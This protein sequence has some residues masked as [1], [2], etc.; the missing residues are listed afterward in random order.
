VV[1]ALLLMALLFQFAVEQRSTEVGTLL[2]LGF[3]PGRSVG[4]YGSREERWRC[5]GAA[6]GLL[7]GWFTRG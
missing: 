6:I 2:A 5:W 3:T 7:G 1:A 4:C